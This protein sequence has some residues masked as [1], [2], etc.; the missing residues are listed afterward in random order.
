MK[1]QVRDNGV[2]VH[3]GVRY[4]LVLVSQL[5]HLH[6]LGGDNDE[7]VIKADRA[8]QLA[9]VTDREGDPVSNVG[10]FKLNFLPRGAGNIG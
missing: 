1:I 4:V 7:D 6:A 10:K 5:L 9:T 8:E 2:K 3:L